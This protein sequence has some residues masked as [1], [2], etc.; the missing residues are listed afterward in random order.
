MYRTVALANKGEFGGTTIQA[1]CREHYDRL[2]SHAP[3]SDQISIEVAD[4]DLAAFERD[5]RTHEPVMART[6]G[7]EP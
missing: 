7:M 6:A 1:P 2:I 5:H 3:G 4:L